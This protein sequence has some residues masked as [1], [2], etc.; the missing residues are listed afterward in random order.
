MDG[1]LV[2]RSDGVLVVPVAR[3]RVEEDTL[4][5]LFVCKLDDELFLLV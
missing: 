5:V 2:Q 3:W 1:A 4:A